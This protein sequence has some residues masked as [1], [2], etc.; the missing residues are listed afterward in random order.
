[1]RKE[2][3][4]NLL[5]YVKYD[6]S[7]VFTPSNTKPPVEYFFN[8]IDQESKLRNQFMAL[9][10]CDRAAYV[11]DVNSS[12]YTSSGVNTSN[13]VAKMTPVENMVFNPDRCNLAPQ[14]FFNHTRNNLKNIGSK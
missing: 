2:T 4:T 8:N 14:P 13:E 1:M 11:P 5:D 6:P 10:N 3:K 12:L 7:V 9:Q